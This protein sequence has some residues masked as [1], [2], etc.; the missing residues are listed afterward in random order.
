[1]YRLLVVEDDPRVAETGVALH[2][3][4]A[5]LAREGMRRR[6]ITEGRTLTSY[7]LGGRTPGGVVRRYVRAVLDGDDRA[8]LELPLPVQLRPSLLRAIEPLPRVPAG[9]LQRRLALATRIVEMTTAAAPRFH[10]YRRRP[11]LVTVPVLAWLL[12]T[13]GMLF[14]VRAI[15]GRGGRGT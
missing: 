1:M 15:A 11:F 9:R 4:G 6:L 13:E 3:V 8:P 5:A 10:S 12:L 14:A 7:V 2:D